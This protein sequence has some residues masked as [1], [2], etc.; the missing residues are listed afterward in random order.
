MWSTNVIRATADVFAIQGA[1]SLLSLL[2]GHSQPQA[3]GV[4]C[5]EPLLFYIPDI[6]FATHHVL[7]ENVKSSKWQN[8]YTVYP[9]R[10]GPQTP[11]PG[12][13]NSTVF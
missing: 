9:K 10:Q 12:S 3:Q 4:L 2:V 7:K 1:S 6:F 11:I 5:H 13:S 8:K